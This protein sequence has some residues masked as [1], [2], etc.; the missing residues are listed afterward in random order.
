MIEV[1]THAHKRIKLRC[2]KSMDR[3]AQI[4]FEKGLM[5]KD[6]SG[7]LRSFIDGLYNYNG[8]AN[9]I[10]IYGDKIFIF[11]GEILITVYTLP[12]RFK[13]AVRKL[14]QRRDKVAK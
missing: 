13:N 12:T 11:S 6:V 8:T 2:G 1:T 5:H 9:N 4:A 3:L 7:S 14:M 10:R